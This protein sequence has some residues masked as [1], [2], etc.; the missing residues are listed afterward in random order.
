MKKRKDLYTIQREKLVVG[1]EN[2]NAAADMSVAVMLSDESN[3]SQKV[4]K[5]SGD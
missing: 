2:I 5:N 1:G 4:M 3:F